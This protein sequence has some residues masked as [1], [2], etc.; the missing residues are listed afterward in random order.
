MI[1]IL[2]AEDTAILRD[3]LSAVL[4]L[5][6]DLQVVIEV[7]RGDPARTVA[8]M[9]G[10]DPDRACSAGQRAY[11]ARSERGRLPRQGHPQPPN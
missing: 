8:A 2:L 5:Q 10:A 3:T 4:D 11:R 9:P 6:Y 1:R 7:D